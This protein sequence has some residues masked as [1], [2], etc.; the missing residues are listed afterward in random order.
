MH[1]A[2]NAVADKHR[3][4]AP[5]RLMTHCSPAEWLPSNGNGLALTGLALFVVSLQTS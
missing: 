2:P 5:V 4:P 3:Y 1:Y